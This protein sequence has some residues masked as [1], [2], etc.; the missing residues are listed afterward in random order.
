M[1]NSPQYPD[2]RWIPPRAWNS[3]RASGQPSVITIHTTEGS[4]HGSSAE[5]GAAY[6]QRRTDGTSAH[7]YIDSNSVI[8]CVRT[9]DRAN[10][11]R[12]TG[13]KIGI[14]YELCGKSGSIDWNSAYAQAML[15][16]AAK[17]AARDAKK[18]GIPVKHLTVAQLKAGQKGFV[19]HIDISNAF[20]QSDHTDPGGRFPWSQFL[21]YVN[22]AMGA[23]PPAAPAPR[24]VTFVKIDGELPVLK[25]GDDEASIPGEAQW[26]KRCQAALSWVGNYDGAIDG[27]Y[28]PK[29]AAAVDRCMEGIPDRSSQDGSIVG[30]PEWR[31]IYGIWN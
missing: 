3:G 11:A 14:H 12:A 29:M 1:A 30:L 22:A 18:H 27:D 7:Y 21:S 6:D 9:T 2:L 15:K 4:A 19:G 23:K 13:N 8:Q 25:R 20:G 16:L 5:D 24:K 26:I 10:T 28:G 17:Q 31:K